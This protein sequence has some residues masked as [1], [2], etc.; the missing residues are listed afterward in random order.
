[1]L[2]NRLESLFAII[3]ILFVGMLSMANILDQSVGKVIALVIFAMSE[4][5][6]CYHMRKRQEAWQK[7][8]CLACGLALLIVVLLF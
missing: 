8:A 2:K 5:M 3:G 4:V 6:T 1:M 7:E